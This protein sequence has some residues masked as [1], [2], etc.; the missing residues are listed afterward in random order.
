MESVAPKASDPFIGKTLC[1]GY[2]V[3]ELIGTG[4]MGR[5]YR[6]EQCALQR[7]VAVKIIHPHLLH[8]TGAA[9][10]FVNEAHAASRLN[11]PNVVSVIDF[12]RT[13]DGLPFIV[14]EYLRGPSLA[15]VVEQ[16]GLLGLAR[17][18]DIVR[19]TLD[20]LSEAH[21]L[22]I[23]HLDLKPANIAIECTRSG[24]DFVKVLD[25]G[26]AQVAASSTSCAAPA[27][28]EVLGTPAYMSPEQAA[29]A[30][31][32]LR[33]DL[34][35]LGVVFYEL[36]TGRRLTRSESALAAVVERMT[37]TPLGEDDIARGRPVPEPLVPVLIKA[38]ASAPA[39]RFGSASEFRQALDEADRRMVGQCVRPTV[40]VPPSAIM[41][42]SC[43]APV[44]A[45]DRF[46]GACGE[47]VCA[48]APTLLALAASAPASAPPTSGVRG[49]HRTTRLHLHAA[50]HKS[51]LHRL[52][53]VRIS[54]T[55][56]MRVARIVGAPG[57]G[58][59]TLLREFLLSARA[60]GDLGVELLPDPDWARPACAGLRS[61]IASL[62]GLRMGSADDTSCYGAPA[63]VVAGLQLV[64]AGK[65]ARELFAASSQARAALRDT[66]RWAVERGAATALT[67]RVA[68]AI[69]DLDRID[70]PTQ[71]AVIDLLAVP[72]N[73][74]LI[75]VAAQSLQAQVDW[76]VQVTEHLL[77]GWDLAT[78]T[79]V[80]ST[81]GGDIALPSDTPQNA[82][83]TPLYVEQLI[84][85][86]FEGGSQPS[87]E[88][89]DLIAR[90]IQALG[91]DARLVLQAMIVLGDRVRLDDLHELL[92]GSDCI[93]R[94][95]AALAQ[96]AM[97]D[98]IGGELV[99]TH[100]LVREV[101]SSTLPAVAR[102]ELRARAGEL[103]ARSDVPL[104]VLAIHARD[105]D[106]WF[107]ALFLMEQAASRASLLGDTSGAVR[108]LRMGYET[109]RRAAAADDLE[110]AEQAG[111]SFGRKLGDALLESG[112][113]GDA[114]AVLREVLEFV[115]PNSAGYVQIMRGLARVQRA[116][117][118]S[119]I[120]GESPQGIKLADHA[121]PRA[122]GM[123]RAS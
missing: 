97:L 123:G 70:G 101:A 92:G 36:A 69:D 24:A 60:S 113:L 74:P 31:V 57:V 61:L 118:V 107:D 93:N 88:T 19:Q 78:A 104:E 83:V 98:R 48:T 95:L 77:S 120:P 15:R 64:F 3:L 75:V 85:F 51:E 17:V 99:W 29:G 1:G 40:P 13:D 81:F 80:L 86:H 53:E 103:R 90:R 111:L 2:L 16:E 55:S 73:A 121:K 84:R 71:N 112:Q 42:G 34:F 8:D 115:G 50:G 56:G 4:G 79:S 49:A 72:P 52:N 87:L 33:S 37:A 109:V 18:I 63:S 5:V 23:V 7:S 20:A 27:R 14:M 82:C 59:T 122:T 35:S 26:L 12:G 38:L 28:R 108:W 46:C 62:A 116:G 6:A 66:L 106:Q 11:H 39:D 102:R 45:S 65:P 117:L 76:P 91:A 43:G 89:S 9:S 22:G 68:I 110:D 54:T 21:E 30:A 25:F 44:P 94:G 114:D 10:R 67:G 32:D 105:A 41:C 58:K 47:R 96:A 119:G 100:P